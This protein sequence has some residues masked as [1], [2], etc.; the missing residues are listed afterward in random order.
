MGNLQK[1][2]RVQSLRHWRRWDFWG[3]TIIQVTPIWLLTWELSYVYRHSRDLIT[4]RQVFIG[5]GIGAATFALALA[6]AAWRIK[7]VEKYCT[8][9]WQ[10]M[11]LRKDVTSTT[12]E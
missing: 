8:K 11:R 1:L 7:F 3:S 9:E 4:I 5:M 2:W 12:T 6:G 10:A